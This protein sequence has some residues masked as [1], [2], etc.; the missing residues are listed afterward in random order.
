ML[1]HRKSFEV[2]ALETLWNGSVMLKWLFCVENFI[3]AHSPA[4]A[5]I[6]AWFPGLHVTE[7]YANLVSSVLQHWREMDARGDQKS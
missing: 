3:A 7:V 5:G 2:F 1:S 6:T 4:R